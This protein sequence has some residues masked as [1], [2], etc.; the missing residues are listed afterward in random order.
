MPTYSAV[1]DFQLKVSTVLSKD[2]TGKIFYWI[3]KD[4]EY[5]FNTKLR[6]YAQNNNKE[7]SIYFVFK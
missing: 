5:Y 7:I 2:D 4:L 3:K 6:N 1:I